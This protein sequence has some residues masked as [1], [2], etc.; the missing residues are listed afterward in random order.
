M[1]RVWCCMV[2]YGLYSILGSPQSLVGEVTALTAF[3]ELVSAALH[4][5]PTTM[6]HDAAVRVLSGF[7][8]CARVYAGSAKKRATRD[9]RGGA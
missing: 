2:L 8:V 1:W 3:R 9:A 7:A 5:A 4:G 6:E